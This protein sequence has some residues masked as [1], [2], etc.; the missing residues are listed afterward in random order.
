MVVMTGGQVSWQLQRDTAHMAVEVPIA[1][2]LFL[3]PVSAGRL[4]SAPALFL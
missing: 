4:H 1:L 3:L 2:P